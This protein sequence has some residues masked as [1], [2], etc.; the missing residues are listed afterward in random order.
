MDPDYE[1]TNDK[2]VHIN[3][4]LGHPVVF[5]EIWFTIFEP[6]HV[7]AYVRLTPPFR[8]VD[9]FEYSYETDRDG[10]IFGVD[11]DHFHNRH[12][13]MTQKMGDAKWQITELIQEHLD[14]QSEQSITHKYESIK[15]KPVHE[16]VKRFLNLEL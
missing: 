5:R 16:R 8:S 9:N 2:V 4:I 15:P 10:D 12:Q 14:W 1:T 13:N 11:T 7:C 6:H 3:I